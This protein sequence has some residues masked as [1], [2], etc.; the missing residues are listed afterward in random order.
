MNYKSALQSTKSMP[1]TNVPIHCPFCP[2]TLSGEP[3]TIWKYNV[4]SHLTCEHPEPVA[5]MVNTYELPLIPGKLLVD[6]FV[7]QQEEKW[8]GISEEATF[9]YRDD[10]E[11]PGSDAIEEIRVEMVK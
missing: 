4:I 6:M 11:L 2:Q 3:R 8:M 5:G 7:S 9:D 10:F 1:C